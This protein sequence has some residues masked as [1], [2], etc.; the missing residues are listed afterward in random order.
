MIVASLMVALACAA[1]P[2]DADVLQEAWVSQDEVALEAALADTSADEHTKLRYLGGLWVLRDKPRDAARV[3]RVLLEKFPEDDDVRTWLASI[4]LEEKNA[5]AV[6][7]VL[8]TPSLKNP[9]Q[10]FIRARAREVEESLEAAYGDLQAGVEQFPLERRFDAEMCTLAAKAGLDSL[11]VRHAQDWMARPGL[12]EAEGGNSAQYEAEAIAH[13]LRGFDAAKPV[14]EVLAAA[15]PSSVPVQ[16]SLALAYDTSGMPKASAAVFESQA[17][18]G[19]NGYLE[20]AQQYAASGDL[21][22]ALEMNASVLDKRARWLQR[23]RIFF[24]ASE[25]AR[26]AA[27][28]ERLKPYLEQAP[29]LRYALAYAFYALHRP[30]RAR[31]FATGL[32]GTAYA[33]AAA[34]LLAAMGYEADTK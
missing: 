14:L 4:L 30:L 13:G 21:R 31:T 2:A 28:E 19:L 3:F 20:A 24:A 22:R 18:R 6:L 33:G 15:F 1:A 17:E 11:A 29:D 26:L 34:S 8:A 16:M 23:A 27:L 5:K 7:R 10:Y 9:A 12:T 25:W 32:Q